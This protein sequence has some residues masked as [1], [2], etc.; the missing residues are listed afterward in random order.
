[1]THENTITG[2]ELLKRIRSLTSRE[3]EVLNLILK[4]LSNDQIAL[5]LFRSPKTVDKHCQRIYR[6]LDVHR[7]VN[8]VRLCLESGYQYSA[9]APHASMALE[10]K[11]EPTL[12]SGDS[13]QLI[14]RLVQKG[15][16]WDRLTELE[17]LLESVTGP[18]YFGE[19]VCAF[20][21]V[22]DVKYAGISEI[23]PDDTCGVVLAYSIDG[24]LVP[25]MEEY[26]I[27][28]TPCQ[29]AL[30][31]GRY[32]VA[33]GVCDIFPS[34]EYLMQESIDSYTGVRLDDRMLNTLGLIWIADVKPMPVEGMFL[35]VLSLIAPAV[36]SELA[37]QVVLDQCG[38][39]G[40]PSDSE[41]GSERN[42]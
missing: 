36:A 33:S 40:L 10:A 5:S 19:L 42:L 34:D 28:G 17:R 15:R 22:F 39:T 2:D 16:A 18:G 25:E 23:R 27:A 24:K 29:N 11:P 7:R 1:M 30:R 13:Y 6:K 26:T 41:S 9:S 31:D 3:T 37:V 8:L 32:T 12:S 20:S 38:D 21:K 14:D 4:G 35:E